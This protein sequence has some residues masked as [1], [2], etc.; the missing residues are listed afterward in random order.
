MYPLKVYF[1]PLRD[2]LDACWPVDIALT[3]ST[4]IAKY[5]I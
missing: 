1:L 2:F 5:K 3:I 4:P